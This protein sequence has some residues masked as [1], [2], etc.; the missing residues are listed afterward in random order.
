MSIDILLAKLLFYVL[1]PLWLLAGFADHLCHRRTHIETTSGARES[2]LHA[3]QLLQIL[4]PTVLGLFLQVNLLVIGLMLVFW[5]LHTAT[6]LW[7]T[8]YASRL[9][10]VSPFEQHVHS[11]VELLPLFAILIAAVLHAN[12]VLT[13]DLSWRPRE[14]PLPAIYSYSAIC[15]MALASIPI[16][17]EWW[18]GW[19][20]A[21]RR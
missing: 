6:A 11:Y 13:G 5:L 19:R 15:A 7:D 1:L 12:D 2:L 9:R 20:A 4:V 10:L 21:R 8:A 3:L 16:A 18:R 14:H 17:E